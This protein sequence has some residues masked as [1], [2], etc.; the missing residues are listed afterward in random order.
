MSNQISTSLRLSGQRFFVSRGDTLLAGCPQG[1]GHIL[2]RG[3]GQG[4]NSELQ[5]RVGGPLTTS[6]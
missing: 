3:V 6:P 2:Q 1:Q 5:E 4:N